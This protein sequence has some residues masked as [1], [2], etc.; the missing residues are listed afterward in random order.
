LISENVRLN[1]KSDNSFIEF[2]K[3]AITPKIAISVGLGLLLHLL[4]ALPSWQTEETDAMEELAELCSSVGGV[5]RCRVMTTT[6]AEGEVTAVA[7][8]CDG[9]ES[10]EVRAKLS[11]LISSLYGIGYHRISILKISQ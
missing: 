11:K 9:A 7:V 2:I 6:D 8:L 4:A 3:G 10:A 5:G 1:L